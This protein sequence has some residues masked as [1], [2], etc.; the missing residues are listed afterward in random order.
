MELYLPIST[1]SRGRGVTDCSVA[2]RCLLLSPSVSPLYRNWFKPNRITGLH[3]YLWKLIKQRRASTPLCKC[4]SG[5][6]WLIQLHLFTAIMTL[7]ILWNNLA[8]LAT[9]VRKMM[10]SFPSLHA[11]SWCTNCLRFRS[12][13][14]WE[15]STSTTYRGRW[16][17]T[18]EWDLHYDP[19][20]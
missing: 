17:Q 6:A 19:N 7:L 16:G 8:T 14:I 15:L 4:L 1:S 2:V 11:D 20:I 3:F 13:F 10:T 9:H 18:S 12:C 5:S